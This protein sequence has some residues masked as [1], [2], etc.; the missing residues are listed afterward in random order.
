M[1]IAKRARVKKEK[2]ELVQTKYKI[3]VFYMIQFKLIKF[4]FIYVLAFNS[5]LR[6]GETEST[7]YVGQ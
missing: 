7:R 3:K 4:L 5:F 2:T 1:S 6:W